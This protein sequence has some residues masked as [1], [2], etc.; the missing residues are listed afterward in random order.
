VPVERIEA[1]TV[2]H[3][4]SRAGDPHR[5]LHLQINA[6]VSA[7]GKWRGLHTVGVRDMIDAINGIDHA[8][9]M[10]EPQFR[11]ALADGGFTLDSQT[12][13]VNELAG[14]AGP[15]SART[16]QIAKNIER[17]ETAWRM[18]HP[19][20]DPGPALIRTWDRRAWSEAR[21]DKVVPTDG[22]VLTDRW[23]DELHRLGFRSPLARRR[24]TQRARALWTVTRR[25]TQS[26]RG[27]G[28][29]DPHGTPPTSAAKSSCSSRARG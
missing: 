29:S 7:E 4:T 2:R 27:S 26:C 19:G 21:P 15:F 22:T 18:A 23:I 12:G 25:S 28:R 9:V 14:F 10:C 8:A 17:Y 24:C 3:Y 16:R 5:H 11:Q 6:R 20:E 13:E 1:A